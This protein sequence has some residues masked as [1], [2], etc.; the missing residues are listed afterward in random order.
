MAKKEKRVDVPNQGH[1]HLFGTTEKS[2]FILNMDFDG[3]QKMCSRF[4]MLAIAVVTLI[5]IP[6]Y[7]TQTVE[8]YTDDD[9]V[10]YMSDNF[11]FY[12]AAM[13]MLA[14]GVGYLVFNVARQK[15]LVDIKNN[16]LLMLPP[17][18]MLMTLISSLAAASK[19]DSLLGYIGR[20]DGFLMTVGCFGLFAVTAA[21]GDKE[22]KK[23]LGDF[24]VAA[25]TL[26]SVIGILEAVPAAA[27]A[28]HN[29][30][31]R[32]Y[33]RPGLESSADANAGEFF[34]P[35]EESRAAFGIY[36]DGKVATGF[37]TSPHALAALIAI[38]FAIAVAG[39]AFDDNKKRRILYGIAAPV[40]AAAACLTKVRAGVICLCAAALTVAVIAFVKAAKGSKGAL[41]VLIPVICSGIAAGTLFGTGTAAFKDEQ[42]IFTDSYV[43]RAIGLYD[44][45][46]YINNITDK[47]TD[48]RSIYSYLFGDAQYV[49]SQ[50][51]ALGVGPD[52][53][54]YHLSEFSLTL[55]RCYNEY[56]DT[57]MQKGI[58]T[59]IAMGVFMLV[60]L[61][62]GFKLAAAFI[63]G[64]GDWIAAAAFGAVV[65]YM[66]QAWFNT[67][68]F[69]AT[70]MFF[71]MAGLCWD[72]S[73]KGGA[74][75]KAK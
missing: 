23:S 73:V 72:I 32:L 57:A 13:V 16:K 52:N 56:M 49:A 29:Y 34:V 25:V 47:S 42:I 8:I 62:K 65:A 51:P 54:M 21:L 2:D 39:V 40:M 58:I 26:Q 11:I 9:S 27:G 70:Y 43:I 75:K 74:K 24:I 3:A 46:D 14:G 12:A 4:C 37:L 60:T 66:A 6:A 31:D 45:Y 20:H 1:K 22:R 7:Y 61:I 68:W 44:R 35:M 15:G 41:T 64:S 18:V 48:T 19:H 38:G 71:I 63:K 67:S 17:A 28:F 36:T 53:A 30:F 5:L 59:L 55:D 10:R 33:L 69:S 50:E